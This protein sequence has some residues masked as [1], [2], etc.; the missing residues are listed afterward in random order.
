MSER[1][2]DALASLGLGGRVEDEEAGPLSCHLPMNCVPSLHAGARDR[3][4]A[5]PP[6]VLYPWVAEIWRAGTVSTGGSRS[7]GHVHVAVYA[8]VCV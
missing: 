5:S 3:P 4:R 1:R 6:S 7:E 2:Q 8:C